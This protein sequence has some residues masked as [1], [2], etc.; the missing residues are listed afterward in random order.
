MRQ[1]IPAGVSLEQLHKPSITS[2]PKSASIFVP[3]DSAVQAPSA[4]PAT[5]AA[6]PM[7]ATLAMPTPIAAPAESMAQALSAPPTTPPTV[8]VPATMATL[9]PIAA[10]ATTTTPAPPCLES[11]RLDTQWVDV[12]EVDGEPAAA[13]TPE[14]PC[15]ES[16]TAAPSSSGAAEAPNSQAEARQIQCRSAAYAIINRELVRRSVTGVFHR[17]VESEKGQEILKDIHQGECGHHAASRTLVAK[18]FHHGFYCPTALEEAVDLVDKCKG[19]QF[20]SAK[21]HM[22]PSALKTIPLSWSFADWGLDMVGPFKT[23]RAG[24]THLLVAVD[25]FTKWIEARPIKKLDGPIAV[26]FITDIS[27]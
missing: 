27:V 14:T 5:P 13:A 16:T 10:P 22:S 20:F 4:P 2:S 1:A 23:A 8:P 18:A 19:C 21:S 11:C 6:A 3:A 9:T 25:K 12:M 7:P 24:M 15:L 26:R 17:C